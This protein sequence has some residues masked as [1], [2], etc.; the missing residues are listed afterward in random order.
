[1]PPVDHQHAAASTHDTRRLGQQHHRL[2]AVQDVEDQRGILRSFGHS[3][4]FLHHIAK[5]AADVGHTF[6]CGTLA[7]A[8]HHLGLNVHRRQDT[9]DAP[10][11][12]Q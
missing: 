2:F 9:S 3:K 8:A 10:C 4:S 7:G 1:M 6:G 12:R 5:L 11:H